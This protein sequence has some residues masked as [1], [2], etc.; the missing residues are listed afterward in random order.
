MADEIPVKI[1]L[2]E[3]QALAALTKLTKKTVETGE[4]GSKAFKGMNSALAVFTGTLGAIGASR[5]LGFI[6]AQ[7]SQ[8]GRGFLEFSTAVAEINSLLPVNERLTIATKRAFIEFSSSFAGDPQTQAKAFYS[9]VSAGVKTTAKQLQVLEI[10]NKAAVAGLVDINTAAF[11]LVSSVNAYAKSGLTAQQASD[12][13]FVAVREGQTTFGELAS[14]IGSV[15]PLA[16]SAGVSFSDL[17]AT[18]AFITKSGVSTDEA[19]TGIR[20]ALT[21]IIKPT[22]GA[23]KAMK[24]LNEATGTNID[25]SVKGIKAI[26][27]FGKFLQQLGVATG[28]S[29][30]KLAKLF[31]NVRAL[32]AVINVTGGNVKDFNRILNETANASGATSAAFEVIS[33]SAGFQFGRLVQELQ[34]IPQAFLLNFEQPIAEGLKSIR[35]FVSTN[36]ILLVVDAADFLIASFVALSGALRETANFFDFLTDAALGTAQ[37]IKEF[38]IIQTEASK[39]E[40]ENIKL[41]R[42]EIQRETNERQKAQADLIKSTDAFRKKISEAR[43]KQVEDNKNANENQKQNDQQAIADELSGQ[44]RRFDALRSIKEAQKEIEA[45]EAEIAKIEAEVKDDEDFQR[46]SN[47]LGREEA[48]QTLFKAK[49]LEEEGKFAEARQKIKAAEQKADKQRIFQT[50]SFEDSSNKERLSNLKS[51]LGTISSLTQSNNEGLFRIGQ[52]AGI[53]NAVI[54]TAEAYT[55]ALASAPPPFNFVLAA[56]VGVAG[57]AQITTI[58]SQSPPKLQE[59]GI[60]PGSSF[61][62]DRVTA[63]VNSGELVLNQ[64]QQRNLFNQIDQGN[65]GGGGGVIVQI[66]GDFIG[67]EENI[68]RMID[69]MN[70]ALEFRNAQLR[71]A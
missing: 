56:L 35:E 33:S 20:A 68:D 65:L 48:L 31:P 61:T 45:E 71:T 23:V 12:A 40:I 26:G 52:A 66:E 50:K 28:G 25:F 69:G 51:T 17:T 60:I 42:A 59:G 37:A 2:E 43:N 54:N 64:R 15:A 22:E 41:A 30:E 63:Q 47:N 36:G 49:Q 1:T 6:S 8:A 57:A 24:E 29:T 58:A 27:G 38:S 3:K 34:N 4:K 11:A 39:R 14:S 62:G 55:K 16:Q 53:A 10:A 9:I 67:S 5:A 32:A 70:D 19:V 44:E 46:L 7:A 21:G 18:L 13:L